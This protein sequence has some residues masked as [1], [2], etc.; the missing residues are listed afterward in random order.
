MCI[1]KPLLQD[2][3]KNEI[4]ILP[5][6]SLCHSSVCS[7]FFP[8]AVR[9][10]ITDVTLT[11]PNWEF[12]LNLH[13]HPSL[14]NFSSWVSRWA[15]S[16]RPTISA[17]PPNAEHGQQQAQLTSFI[18]TRP[19]CRTSLLETPNRFLPSLLSSPMQSI[20]AENW[21]LPKAMHYAPDCPYRPLVIQQR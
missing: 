18:A 2:H 6:T 11:F 5:A 9:L 15:D 19:I 13:S 1:T 12:T 7:N 4:L 8:F 17:Q 20:R 16:W 21:E 3:G 14:G 10:L